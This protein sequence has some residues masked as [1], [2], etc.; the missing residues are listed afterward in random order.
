MS[1]AAR[2]VVGRRGRR[3]VRN[4]RMRA[5]VLK[6]CKALAEAVSDDSGDGERLLKDLLEGLAVFVRSAQRRVET[7]ARGR[8]LA[9]LGVSF[10]RMALREATHRF[11]RELILARVEAHGGDV[12]AARDSLGLHKNTFRYRLKLL[13]LE[14]AVRYGDVDER[15]GHSG[16]R[17][18]VSAFEEEA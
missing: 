18:R 16:R 8:L 5:D 15:P 11:Q 7:R 4:S 12:R 13:G 9:T 2:R 1:M 17:A 6:D 14:E 10:Q 3:R